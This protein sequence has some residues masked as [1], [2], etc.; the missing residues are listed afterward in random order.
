MNIYPREG[1]KL[2]NLKKWL[3]L[4]PVLKIIY[5]SKHDTEIIGRKRAVIPLSFYIVDFKVSD[6]EKKSALEAYF[7]KM[8]LHAV[9]FGLEINY[10]K[11]KDSFALWMIVSGEIRA[12]HP[13]CDSSVLH[14]AKHSSDC[15]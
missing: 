4:I 6:E 5:I 9:C 11:I 8:C 13:F 14:E 12:Y 2:T 10:C 7:H 3:F 15:E 1:R